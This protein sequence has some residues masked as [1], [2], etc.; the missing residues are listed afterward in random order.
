MQE[1][2]MRCGMKITNA[3]DRVDRKA[4]PLCEH[5]AREFQIAAAVEQLRSA[6]GYCR[7]GAYLAGVSQFIRHIQRCGEYGR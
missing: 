4:A 3:W 6:A 5:C 1:N 7:C 2:C